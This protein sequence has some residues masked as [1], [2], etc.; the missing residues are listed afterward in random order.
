M[1]IVLVALLSKCAVIDID[2]GGGPILFSVNRF[3]CPENRCIP[4]IN[5]LHGK[6][7]LSLLGPLLVFLWKRDALSA[8]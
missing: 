8:F 1:C 5:I 3:T 7:L 6:K 2:I 4:D